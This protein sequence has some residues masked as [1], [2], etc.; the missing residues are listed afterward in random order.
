[1]P[2]SD[3]QGPMLSPRN[4][5]A[6]LLSAALTGLL[7]VTA[8]C[9]SEPRPVREVDAG[10]VTDRGA[11]ATDTVTATD[12]GTATDT[13]TAT[14]AVA[15]DVVAAPDV[16]APTDAPPSTDTAASADAPLAQDVAAPT[17]AAAA[18]DAA[19]PQD[20]TAANDAGATLDVRT[21][22]VPFVCDVQAD[23]VIVYSDATPSLPYDVFESLCNRV[24]GTIEIHPHCGGANSCGGFSYDQTTGV[25]T[26]HTCQGLNTC[27]GYTCV[28]R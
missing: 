15:A 10:N 2:H 3:P 8:S 22:D 7:S 5:S 18:L 14:D 27:T 16:V 24:G 19:A 4:P 9:S 21:G 23:R 28:R 17:D 11:A 6:A 20:A 12:R 25:Y 1:M 13:V 26:E